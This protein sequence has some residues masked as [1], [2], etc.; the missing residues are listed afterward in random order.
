MRI[1][2]TFILLF[3][4][5]LKANPY[6]DLDSQIKLNLIFNHFLNKEI[7]ENIPLKPIKEIL[8]DDGLNIEPIKYEKYFQYIQRIKAIHESRAEAQQKINDKYLQKVEFY[9]A[10]L[11]LL[12]KFYNKPIN[13][14]PILQ[15]SINKTFKVVYGK[16][17]F[18]NLKYS[19]D[20]NSIE[21]LLFVQ[22]IYNIE[23][24]N[25]KEIVISNLKDKSNDFLKIY[26]DIKINVR[27]KYYNDILSLKDIL[28]VFD[29]NWYTANFIEKTNE[30]FKLQ[31][32]I[33]DDIFSLIKIQNN[34]KKGNK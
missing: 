23:H 32:K 20:M 10:K 25:S 34:S 19:K 28:F 6:K 2:I 30:N 29:S 27:F 26:Q 21:G 13:L 9:N 33:N 24:F 8:E 11:K 4:I 7:K 31:I 22:N 14:K 5:A 15:N 16:P 12:K 3:T 18:K 17:I 1:I